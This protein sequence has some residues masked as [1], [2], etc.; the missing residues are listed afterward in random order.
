MQFL[1]ALNWLR[2]SLPR[3]T[4]VVWP[5]CVFLDE[6][7][8]SAKRR[9]E[10][11]AS[12]RAIAAGEWIPELI[13]AWDVARDLVAQAVALPHPKPGWAVLMFPDASDDHR[14]SFL[15]QVP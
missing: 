10:R 3:I 13:G 11:V 2:T 14:G 6:S 4:E 7:M 1:Q 15:T 9:T 8:A 5:L 12:T